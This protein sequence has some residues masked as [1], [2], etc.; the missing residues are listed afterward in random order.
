MLGLP[1]PPACQP[2]VPHPAHGMTRLGTYLS[3]YA[4]MTLLLVGLVMLPWSVSCVYQLDLLG[5]LIFSTISL[6]GLQVTNLG[7]GWWCCPEIV[8]LVSQRQQH[9]GFG[10]AE[11]PH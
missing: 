7:L 2:E 5:S 4:S 6:S 3:G 10:Y 1:H 9:S 11:A 8:Q